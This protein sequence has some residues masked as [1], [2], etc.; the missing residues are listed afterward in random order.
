M[1]KYLIEIHLK[2][3]ML[4]GSD[5]IT[6]LS[7]LQAVQVA[8]TPV[9]SSRARRS[10]SFILM[11]KPNRDELNTLTCLTCSSPHHDACS[12][13]LACQVLSSLSMKYATSEL[14]IESYTSI[15]A[16]EQPLAKKAME[17]WQA[18][19]NSTRLNWTFFKN[20]RLEMTSIR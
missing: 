10:D 14:P 11:K 3:Y 15:L 16:L 4:R 7:F 19:R 1:A 9:K 12:L 20:R 17:Y 18:R 6:I 5:L 2:C 13:I 8:R